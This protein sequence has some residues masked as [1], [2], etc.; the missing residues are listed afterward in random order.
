MEYENKKLQQ[1]IKD[2]KKSFFK[3][4]LPITIGMIVQT[5]YN[6]VD[7][8]YIGRLGSESI[9]ALTFTMPVFFML[10]AINSGISSGTSSRIS[11][12]LGEKNYELAGKVVLHGII[13]SI[14][15]AILISI[16]GNVFVVKFFAGLGA[17]G[18]TLKLA[19]D[20][21][22]IILF[23]QVFLFLVYLINNVFIAQGHSRIAT[24]IQIFSFIVNLILDPIFI[25]GF[26]LGVAGAAWATFISFTTGFI[27]SI[28][29]LKKSPLPINFKLFKF[30]KKI[31]LEILKVGI[32]GSFMIL[33]MSINGLFINKFMSLF[34]NEYVAVYGI[35]NR[36]E[37][38]AIMPVVALSVALMTMVGMFYGAKRYDLLKSIIY[39]AIKAG[40]LLNLLLILVFWLTP[41]IFLTIFTNDQNLINLAI[42]Y[43]RLELLTL[44][45]ALFT[46]II[47]RA[48]QGMGEGIP[49]FVI[50][51]IR[52]IIITIPLTYIFIFVLNWD[53]LSPPIAAIIGGVLASLLAFYW[54]G[55]KLKKISL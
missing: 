15:L 24:K 5:L 37:S 25:Y 20:Y 40:L 52:L 48:L 1:F 29:S 44:P 51:V 6:V 55:V 23:G 18:N 7:A 17:S 36:L 8:A 39:F 27:Y 32:P 49:A 19:I 30:D 9:A 45:L 3:L 4:A 14:I 10:I 21:F 54:L 22:R 12:A 31:I 47:G 42:P 38:I 33:F 35:V 41:E 13:I 28:L 53:Y 2:P 43:L 34:G 26:H 11:R 16:F 50:T 46:N